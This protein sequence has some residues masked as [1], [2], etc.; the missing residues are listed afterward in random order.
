MARNYK[1]LKIFS[2]SY[3]FLLRIYSD[4]LPKLPDSE[5][6]NIFSQLQR[7]STSV[8]LNIAEGASHTSNKV[9]F[10][11]LQYSFG[12]C[13]EVD[14][15]L[16]LCFD[17]GFI[18]K[19]MFFSLSSDL[20]YVKASLFRFMSSV[21]NQVVKRVDNFSFNNFNSFCNF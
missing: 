20:E 13:K 8:V 5:S 7:A 11:H 1:N 12:S 4:V 16:S 6:R 10:N 19:D 15:L 2:L 17:L 3:A 18:D 21:D 9:F 14:V